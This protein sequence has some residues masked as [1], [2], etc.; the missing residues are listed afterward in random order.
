MASCHHNQQYNLNE[1]IS[2]SSNN[3]KMTSNNQSSSSSSST[4]EE[5]LV[6]YGSQTGNSQQAAEQIAASIPLKLLINTA[7]CSARCMHL[8]DFLEVERAKWTRL[9]VI[10]CSSYG[11]GQAPLGARKFREVCD[12]ILERRNKDDSNSNNNKFLEGVSFALLGLGDSHYTTFFQNPT[13]INAAL[14]SAGA[15]RVGELGKADASGTGH[16]EQ[17]KVIDRWINAIYEDLSKVV[18]SSNKTEDKVLQKASEETCTA[19][20]KRGYCSR[21]C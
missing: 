9:A 3:N 15:T 7:P 10:V 5:I 16:M 11:V 1:I 12:A 20:E 6:L 14:T 17:S 2:K 18:S 21:Y 13:A 8:D 4:P 19:I